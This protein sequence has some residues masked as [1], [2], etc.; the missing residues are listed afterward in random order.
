MA[1]NTTNVEE[2]SHPS[3]PISTRE[4]DQ[5]Q[6]AMKQLRICPRKVLESLSDIRIE[7]SRIQPLAD[8]EPK[9]GGKADV[10]E[11]ILL[12]EQPIYSSE[13]SVAEYVA[14]K[15]VRFDEET[16]DDRVLASFA[17]E[18]NLLNDLFHENVVEIIGFVE[19][20]KEGI[21]WMLFAWEQNGNLRE[22]V[23]SV[24]WELPERA[25]LLNILVNSGNRAVITDFGSARAICNAARE[26][27]GDRPM[28]MEQQL[29]PEDSMASFKAEVAPTGESITMT[30]PAWTIR[31]AAPELLE[32][33]LPDLASDIWAFG[34]IYW[35]IITGNFPFSNENNITIAL[36]IVRGDI[37][38]VRDNSQLQQ[39]KALCSLMMECWRLDASK[40]P[41]VIQCRTMLS[42]LVSSVPSSRHV[43]NL[44]SSRSCGLCY[45]LGWMQYKNGHMHEA[46]R[47]LEQSSVIAK[48]VGDEETN[49]SSLLALGELYHFTDEYSRA[50]S[51][52]IEARNSF[53]RVSDWSGIGQSVMGL[54]E[55]YKTQREYSKAEDAYTEARS[56]YSKMVDRLGVA[57]FVKRLGDVYYLRSEYSKAEDAFTE[58]RDVYFEI[59]G[60]GGFTDSLRRL[61]GVYLMRGEYSEAE[62]AYTQAR[63]ICAHSGDQLSL[64]E[65][66]EGLGDVYRMQ[67]EYSKAESAYT[68][69]REVC[70][71]IGYQNGVAASIQGLGDVYQTRSEYSKAEDAY[72]EARDIFS[73]TGGQRGVAESVQRLGEVY[74]MQ[75]KYFKAEDA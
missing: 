39:M 9:A 13:P 6:D 64:A 25:S 62:E 58:P 20:T 38:D 49:A 65:S 12:P 47:N 16:D 72:T 15:K 68:E 7:K 26:A 10:Q 14:V 52:Y 21:A 22:F 69:A 32:G 24:D 57:H 63:D 1:G 18:V 31:W 33:R 19:D 56:I 30:G 23:R 41:S 42:S 55:V 61:G 73:R 8:R 34:W 74:C 29:P 50:E 71:R 59:G 53:S 27:R 51:L 4:I 2:A 28:R 43:N 60:E 40:R 54:G 11:A 44:P 46:R 35:E 75:S 17:H 66:M 5:V 48:S 3:P 67:R 70:S 45:A 36:R 37:P